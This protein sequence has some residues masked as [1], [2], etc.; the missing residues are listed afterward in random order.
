MSWNISETFL[1][2]RLVEFWFQDDKILEFETLDAVCSFCRLV[3][4][5]GV[6]CRVWSSCEKREVTCFSRRGS[7]GSWAA[8][9]RNPAPPLWDT[10]YITRT[11][12]APLSTFVFY[13]LCPSYLPIFCFLWRH[14]TLPHFLCCN[15]SIYEW[16]VAES[17][18]LRFAYY[19]VSQWNERVC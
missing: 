19:L 18:S 1:C 12:L 15:R 4:K 6:E 2:S 16:P 7:V 5:T 14:S 9:F 8:L 3:N 17:S 13:H 10:T 11:C